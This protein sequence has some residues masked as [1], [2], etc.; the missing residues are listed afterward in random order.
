MHSKLTRTCFDVTV[1]FDPPEDVRRTWKIDRD[2]GKRG[3]HLLDACAA[4]KSTS[5]AAT[6]ARLGP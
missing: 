4:P 1:Y 3:Y 6:G 5:A 2:T